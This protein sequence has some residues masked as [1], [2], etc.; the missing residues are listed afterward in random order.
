MTQ[1]IVLSIDGGGVRGLLSACVLRHI[2]QTLREQN[3]LA[4]NG[5]AYNFDMVVGT[6]SGALLGLGL[7]AG[8]SA[9]AMVGVYQSQAKDIFSA[10]WFGKTFNPFIGNKGA[11]YKPDGLERVLQGML[12][13][14]TLGQLG[15]T[16]EDGQRTEGEPPFLMCT[17]YDTQ[18]ATPRFFKSWKPGHENLLAWQV[19]RASSAAPTYFPPKSM[20]I[21]KGTLNDPEPEATLIDGGLFANNPA[22]SAWAEAKKL[23]PKDDILI[24]SIGSGERQ[25]K[26]S[27]ND[28]PF[29]NSFSLIKPT[30][31]AMFD[32]QSDAV[33]YQLHKLYEKD[34]PSENADAI[35]NAAKYLRLQTDL[36]HADDALDNATTDNLK[37][38]ELDAQRL[39]ASR[40][41][42]IAEF[43]LGAWS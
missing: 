10:S 40:A 20:N 12:T 31:N 23:W 39:I 14:R 8:N 4:T 35:D 24:L 17:A 2:E 1:R 43:V 7:A 19:A 21:P 42:D 38:L 5:I 29:W 6:S 34:K 33:D 25:E 37:A 28:K 16:A 9:Q 11:T 13:E 27:A 30:F 22:M 36:Q 26:Y 3:K 32:G 41:Q 18:Q 15:C